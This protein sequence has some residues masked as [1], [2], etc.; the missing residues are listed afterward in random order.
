MTT[1]KV[2]PTSKISKKFV[3]IDGVSDGDDGKVDVQKHQNLLSEDLNSPRLRLHRPPHPP[4][5]AFLCLVPSPVVPGEAQ[6]RGALRRRLSMI[7]MMV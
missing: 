7:S 2:T 3:K 4:A 1:T 5:L 6:R